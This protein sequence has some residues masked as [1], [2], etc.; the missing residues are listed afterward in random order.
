LDW[1]EDAYLHCASISI[2]PAN[3]QAHELYT[4]PPFGQIGLTEAEV[5]KSGKPALIG[6][7]PMTK[8][9]RAVEKGEMMGFMKV[10]VDAE[11]RKILR[12]AIRERAETKRFTAFWT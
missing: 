4:D 2:L 7:R 9:G 1:E 12:A 10:L 11:S 5:R 3:V 8:V 6:T